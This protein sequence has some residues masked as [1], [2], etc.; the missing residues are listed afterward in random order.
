M[1]E[2]GYQV[3]GFSNGSEALGY[4][5][6]AEQLTV[7]VVIS[8]LELSHINGLELLS[9]FQRNGLD[10]AF[11][12]I[13]GNATTDSAIEAVNLGAFAYHVKPLD[14]RELL[15]S[16]RQALNKQRLLDEMRTATLDAE[17]A[18]IAKSRFLANM[19]HEIRTPMNGII[20]LTKLILDTELTLDQRMYLQSVIGSSHTL[21]TVVNDILDFSKIEAGKIELESAGFSPK[22]CLREIIAETQLLF[23]QKGLRIE[24][25]VQDQVPDAVLGDPTRLKQILGN[26]IG[27]ALK[28]TEVG[29]VAVRVELDT[30]SVSEVSLRFL[31][32][33]TGIGIRAE[34]MGRIFQAF[35]Q[36][37]NSTTRRF[38]ETG[39]GLSISSQLVALMGGQLSAESQQGEGS[40]FQ[41]TASFG[42]ER[43]DI[44]MATLA[45]A[46][47]ETLKPTALI[48]DDDDG[49]CSLLAACLE[50]RSWNT[51]CAQ[52]GN[53]A[54][55]LLQTMQVNLTFLDLRMPGLDGAATFKAIRAI[56]PFAKVV[57]VTGDPED[58]IMRRAWKVGTFSLLTKPFTVRDLDIVLEGMNRNPALATGA[59]TAM[60]TL[61]PSACSDT[62]V[63]NQTPGQS[64][65]S[66][67]HSNLFR[68]LNVL[69]A[70][71][72]SVN[73]L[74]ATKLLE[75]QGHI[76]SLATN[77]RQACDMFEPGA[78]DVV[79]MDV[80]MP[81][82]D[83]LEAT[84]VIRE[85]EQNTNSHTPII[86]M[87][88]HAMVGDKEICLQSGMDAYIS[89]PIELDQ[90]LGMITELVPETIEAES[91]THEFDRS[92]FL[93]RIQ[94][95]MDL[96]HELVDQFTRDQVTMLSEIRACIRHRDG[97][98]LERVG[99]A[100]KG[101]LS[102]FSAPD[103][104]D[105]AQKLE[106]IGRD[107]N[108][109][110]S[111]QTLADLEH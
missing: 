105:S 5:T 93:V 50:G 43:K 78:F 39:L 92:A 11:I 80:Q 12:L 28:F 35:S 85:K 57:I 7:H 44:E 15:N 55:E 67:G 94:G 96:A 21:L 48:V 91:E 62:W 90:L 51:V 97:P 102:N 26:L 24:F 17:A 47:D 77:G 59:T 60:S 38:G 71:D 87:T 37:D 69:L 104:I 68:P 106:E 103:S 73:Q 56:N 101:C 33:D 8:E 3:L 45:E 49:V 6:A 13:A 52:S 27:N 9:E 22:E 81:I 86:A 25:E 63:P 41:F 111:N 4:S 89:K 108:L 29:K 58:E 42:L 54:L 40:T 18:N 10:A 74:L 61:T 1:A 70:E 109:D 30:S 72:N 2:N 31:V 36:A 32:S 14:T 23:D 19:S 20:G 83:G 84:A 64:Q 82:I 100:M 107:G 95:D 34:D 65:A 66:S 46:R 98:G 79:L 110:Q 99:H 76:V 16:V 88:A 53:K 75:G